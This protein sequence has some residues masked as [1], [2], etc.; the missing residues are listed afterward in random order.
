MLRSASLLFQIRTNCSDNKLASATKYIRN[1]TGV[2][3]YVSVPLFDSEGGSR[4]GEAGE[5]KTEDAIWISETHSMRASMQVTA[6]ISQKSLQC[7]DKNAGSG[8]QH[9]DCQL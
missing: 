4:T 1:T 5:I 6:M 3:Y 8:C 7:C 9:T 2:P